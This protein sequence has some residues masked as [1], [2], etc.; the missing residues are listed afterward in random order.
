MNISKFLFPLLA[1]FVILAFG[2]NYVTIGLWHDEAFSIKKFVLHDFIHT[3]TYYP[4]PNNHIF[5]NLFNNAMTRLIGVRDFHELLDYI[6]VLRAIQGMISLITLSYVFRFAKKFF[7]L[8]TAWIAAIVFATT[9]PFLNYMVQLR[10]YNFSMLFVIMTLF[11]AYSYLSE[12][13]RGYLFAMIGS[14]FL[15]IYTMPSN[16]YFFTALMLVFIF[17]WL[18]NFIKNKDQ[19]IRA[20]IYAGANRKYWNLLWAG[21]AS[22]LFI[23]IAY[24]P[25]ISNMM[26]DKYLNRVPD[27]RF[28]ALSVRLPDYIEGA[29]SGRNVLILMALCATLYVFRLEKFKIYRQKWFGL[30]FLMLMPFVLSFLQNTYPL[31]RSFV[32]ITPIFALLVAIPVGLWMQSVDMKKTVKAVIVSCI[33]AY[34]IFSLSTEF[35]TI[36]HNLSENLTTGNRAQNNYHAYYQS[37]TYNPASTAKQ[38][39]EYYKENPYPVVMSP[40]EL[41]A[42]TLSDYLNKYKIKNY[43]LKKIKPVNNAPDKRHLK[44]LIS[45]SD[46]SEEP[47]ILEKKTIPFSKKMRKSSFRTG[48]FAALVDFMNSKEQADNFYVIASFNQKFWKQFANYYKDEYNIEQLNQEENSFN[49]YLFKKKAELTIN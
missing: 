47:S 24:S 45:N 5:F 39:L 36:Q 21:A 49:I 41:D 15:L 19:D 20:R 33:Y 3:A 8:E 16:V 10:G 26:T 17:S 12:Q 9:I 43:F 48:R 40:R 1:V 2:M 42:V 31:A 4:E 32:H 6:V 25:V 7:N 14:L 46:L 11:Y 22:L 13:R 37:H 29:I 34:C 27:D 28:F 23:I 30:L 44:V 18:F 38:M 35:K